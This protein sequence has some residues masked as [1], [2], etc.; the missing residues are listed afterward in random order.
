MGS[1]RKKRATDRKPWSAPTI[2]GHKREKDP[3][4]ETEK[5]PVI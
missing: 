5:D 3:A 1:P 4:K 2:R